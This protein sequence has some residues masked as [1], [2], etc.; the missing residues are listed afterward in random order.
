MLG[1][2][3]HSQP[4]VLLHHIVNQTIN[5]KR[6]HGNLGDLADSVSSQSS[7][8]NVLQFTSADGGDEVQEV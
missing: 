7:A 1:F 6:N 8:G 4:L 5:N 2:L 3:L